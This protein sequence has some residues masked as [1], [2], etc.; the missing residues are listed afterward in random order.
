MTEEDTKVTFEENRNN[1]ET[2]VALEDSIMVKGKAQTAASK[3]LDG[4][5]PPFSATVCDRLSRRGYKLIGA[6]FM[7]E[8]GILDLNI[9]DRPAPLGAIASV[10]NGSCDFALCN[11][12]FGSYRR[13]AAK[14]SL[15]YIHPT[16][17]TVSKYGL[18]PLASSMD[19]IGIVSGNLKKGFD[20]LSHIGGF[21]EKDGAMFPEE[22]YNYK[23]NSGNITL[24]LSNSLIE[25]AHGDSKG[26]I[27]DFAG[28]FNVINV[29][30]KYFD[31]YNR[32]MYILTSAEISNNFSRY[33][34][35]RYGYRAKDYRDLD[36]LYT[37]TRSEGFG[38]Q[39]KLAIIMGAA[40]LSK[41]YYSPF[42]EK[43]MKLRRLIKNNLDELFSGGM[44]LLILP[45]KISEDA[46]ENL[47]LYSLPQLLG[48]PS[49]SFSYKGFGIQ[50]VG[51][52]KGEDSLLSA[53]EVA[54]A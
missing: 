28:K 21:D 44:D 15:F 52:P 29:D 3:I 48:L 18:I 33:D 1:R 5:I 51:R 10:K 53:W 4:F 41:D 27:L 36:G 40:V 38:P 42:F 14:E 9:K 6:G 45:T 8:F 13:E 20:L 46:Y 54:M 12:L 47:S 23:N 32:V 30:L 50:L 24:G 17:G 31:L 34:G 19:Q 7:D 43:A 25:M 37:K 2:T 26:A 49:V 11:D 39:V 22:S 35:I 16:Y